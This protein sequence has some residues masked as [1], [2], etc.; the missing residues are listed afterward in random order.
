M[1]S[2][3]RKLDNSVTFFKCYGKLKREIKS[4]IAAI[5]IKRMHVRT[6]YT[7][8]VS[9]YTSQYAFYIF[10][11][12][13]ASYWN[14]SVITIWLTATK[15]SYLKLQIRIFYFLRRCFLSSI[16]AKTFTWLDCIGEKHDGCLIRSRNCLSFASTWVHPWFIFGGVRVFF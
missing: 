5:I 16:T 3:R 11:F 2:K 10:F 14:S 6:V 15:Y 7:T 12:F 9:R 8:S 4:W 1:C 13:L